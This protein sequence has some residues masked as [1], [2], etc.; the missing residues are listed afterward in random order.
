[1]KILTLASTM[2]F[3]AALA[4]A[5]A[6]GAGTG[7]TGPGTASSGLQTFSLESR[8]ALSNIQTT[9]TPQIPANVAQAIQGGALEFRHLITW[10]PAA[11]TAPGT[12]PTL[13]VDAFLVQPGSPASTPLAMRTNALFSYNVAVDNIYLS[14]V[15][16]R[17]I[18]FVGRVTSHTDPSPFGNLVGTAAAISATYDTSASIT[19]FSNV[20]VLLGGVGALF[21]QS[22]SGTISFQTTG[23]G[24][25]TGTGGGTGADGPVAN[26]GANFSTTLPE[27][28]LNGGMSTGTGL[29]Y[30]WR[31]LPPRT[32]GLVGADTATPRVQFGEGYGDYVYELT[33]TDSTG[34]KSTATVTIL[35]I[36]R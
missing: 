31:L 17:N 36:G 25:G 7:S 4:W 10:V 9:L 16:T 34:R 11:A 19:A 30:S 3:S 2:A 18:V 6:G 22:G 21:S 33:V 23:G 26:A 14:T 13:R 12:N 29:T 8:V 5:Q 15:P 27:V 35:Y 28:Q 1:M 20:T 24:T 32:A